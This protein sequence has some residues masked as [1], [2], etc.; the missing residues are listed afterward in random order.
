MMFITI[1]GIDG[2]GK[3]VQAQRLVEKLTQR[4][5]SVLWT[6]EPGDWPS[7]AAVRSLLL[8]GQLKHPMSELLLFMADRCEHVK[9][10]ILPAL[11][12]GKYVVCERYNDSTL[13]YQCWGRGVDR[14]VADQL[15]EWCSLPVPDLTFWLDLTAEEAWKRRQSR[16]GG[17]RIED[18]E[19]GFHRLIA[20]GFGA[21]AAREPH[22]IFRVD[23][24]RGPGEVASDI[25]NEL[26]RREAL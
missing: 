21:L 3:T 22:R 1:E 18:E 6:R 9:Q 2:S 25:E 8:T 20:C 13:A 15:T 26:R 14:S 23:A 17:D 11:E 4:G 10:V 12:A 7:G 16:G 24:S 19:L 5:R